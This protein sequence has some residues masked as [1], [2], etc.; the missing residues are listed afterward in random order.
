MPFKKSIHFFSYLL[1]SLLISNSAFSQGIVCKDLPDLFRFYLLS[2]VTQRTISPEIQKGTA[3]QYLQSID[4][5]KNLILESQAEFIRKNVLSVFNTMKVGD[6]DI[7]KK[8]H[9]IAVEQ[10]KESE[11]MVRK[12]LNDK[13]AVDSTAEIVIDPKKRNFPKTKEE[14]EALVKKYVHFQMANYLISD[15]KMAEA[16][17][18]LIHRYELLVKRLQEKKFEDFLNTFADSFSQSLDPHS[19]YFSPDKL[20]DFKIDMSLSLEGIGASLS[21]QDGYTVV[22]EIIPG[23]AAD[24]A[25]ILR[26][27]DKIISVGQETG[28]FV[29][30]IDMDLR[31]VVKLIRGKK[32]TKVRLNI[33]RLSGDKTERIEVSIIRDKVNL[34]ESAARIR[35]EK[36][37]RGDNVYN[38]AVLDLPSFYGDSDRSKRSSFEDMKKLLTEAS[39]KKVDGIVLNL[40]RNGGGLLDD[41]YKIGGLF[42]RTGPI[43]ATKNTRSEVDI[44]SDKDDSLVYSGPL[45][46]LTSRVSAS[47]SE[48]LAGALQDYDRALVVGGDHT[49][50]KGSVQAVI[51][52]P[53]NLGAIKVTTG[54]FY[55]PAGASTQHQG[56]PGSIS[57]PYSFNIDDIGEKALDYSLPPSKIA[58]FKS[59]TANFDAGPK[60][61]IPIDKTKI[62]LFV[63]RSKIRVAAEPKFAEITK[64][65]AEAKKNEGIIK[66]SEIQNPSKDKKKKDKDKDE[67]KSFSE[68]VRQ[69]DAPYVQESLQILTDLIQTQKGQVLK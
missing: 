17:K 43:V 56:V 34:E 24:R 15:M 48:I 27:K 46:I 13:Y 7:F 18:N 44:L 29:N 35:Y 32:G 66:V 1:L 52:L 45:V 3:E 11:S 2:H 16:K 51:P 54:M 61:W 10:A 57:I 55:L 47:A 41:A 28:N 25:K 36:V 62:P 53:K 22:E 26:N 5:S 33:L 68:R 59:D 65:L 30:V 38:L 60:R 69:A 14:K 19:S 37:V 31:D 64:E 39:A 42:I 67:K 49:F 6:C 8:I 21:S 4:P 50:G 23:G 12:I 58:S 63:E 40:A 20:D 9:D